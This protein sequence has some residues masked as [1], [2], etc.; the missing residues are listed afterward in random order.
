MKLHGRSRKGVRSEAAVFSTV[1]GVVGERRSP[2]DG[3]LVDG[4][5]SVGAVALV[6]STLVEGALLDTTLA[7]LDLHVRGEEVA[8]GV[9]ALLGDDIALSLAAR[10]VKVAI[11]EGLD[12]QVRICVLGQAIGSGRVDGA[13]AELRLS[14]ALNSC[15]ACV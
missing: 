1:T 9:G 13:T 10:V 7:V 6:P 11:T 12:G 14:P 5:S 2:S 3:D 15:L 4:V 8:G